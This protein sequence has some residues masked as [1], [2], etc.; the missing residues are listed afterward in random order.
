MAGMLAAGVGFGIDCLK[1][2]LVHESLDALTVNRVTLSL[3]MLSHAPASVKRRLQVL[4]V[5]EAH[6]F[7]ISCFDT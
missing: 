5:N 7:Q 1:T 3:Q 2:H 6:Q 4:L